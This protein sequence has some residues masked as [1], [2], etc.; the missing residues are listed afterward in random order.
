VLLA[1]RIDELEGRAG[2]IAVGDVVQI[3]PEH[4]EKFG[5]CYLTVTEVKAWAAGTGVVGHVKVPGGGLAFYRIRAADVADAIA[6]ELGDVL[7]HLCDVFRHR[8][9]F[10]T[11]RLAHKEPYT[12]RTQNESADVHGVGGVDHSSAENR[13]ENNGL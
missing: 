11:A 3:D 10:G 12:E 8:R 9:H 6:I 13:N 1:D 4:D 5:A 2:A 7:R